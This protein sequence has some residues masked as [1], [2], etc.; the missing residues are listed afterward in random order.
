M[1]HFGNNSEN[2]INNDSQ[3]KIKN[4]RV[5]VADDHQ[6]MLDMIVKLLNPHCEVVGTAADGKNAL[7]MIELLKPE[8]AV[9]DISMPFKTG[10]EIAADLK[11]SGSEVKIVIITAHGDEF[12]MQTAIS[13]GA[14]AFVSKTRLGDEL[15]PALENA[16]AGKIFVSPDANLNDDLK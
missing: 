11:T 16:Y 6:P 15:L 7:Q 12:Y 9:L 2:R 1:A 3:I 10:I 13:A 5:F 4:I 14:S 8:I